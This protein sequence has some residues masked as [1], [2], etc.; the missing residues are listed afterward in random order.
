MNHVQFSEAIQEVIGDTI[1]REQVAK[2]ENLT[3]EYEDSLQRA[4]MLE[5]AAVQGEITNRAFVRVTG[6][7]E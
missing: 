7:G 5:N 2:I 3:Y 4:V 1:T 6:R